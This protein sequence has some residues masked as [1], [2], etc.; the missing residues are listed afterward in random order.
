M[1]GS[2]DKGSRI[3]VAGGGIGGLAAALGLANKG[4]A[5]L[6]LEKS[7]SLGEIGAGSPTPR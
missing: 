7:P 6:V 3:I 1:S 2:G 5:V 4:R